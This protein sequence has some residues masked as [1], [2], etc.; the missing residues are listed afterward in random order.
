MFYFILECSIS[1]SFVLLKNFAPRS[2]FRSWQQYKHFRLQLAE[3]LI[4]TYNNRKR[5]SLPTDIFSTA[6]DLSTTP[7]KR[8]SFGNVHH[9]PMKGAK[10][11]MLSLLVQSKP[12]T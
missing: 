5:Y 2:D 8:R 3:N 11:K 7:T 9:F 6:L 10:K 4:S 12:K 1:N